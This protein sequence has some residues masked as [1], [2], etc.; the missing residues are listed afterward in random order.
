MTRTSAKPR[1]AKKPRRPQ[2]FQLWAE[3]LEDRNLLS[4]GQWAAF[5][6]GMAP[7]LTFADQ[8]RHGDNLLRYAG[9]SQDVRV[10]E[11][12]DM[13]G[14]FRLSTPVDWNQSSLAG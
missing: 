6:G 10:V 9:V 7:G 12:L 11:A 1:S 5:F 14:A 2:R 3:P 8:A 4:N 13:S